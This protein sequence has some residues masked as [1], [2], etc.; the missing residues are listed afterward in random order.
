MYAK[1]RKND[2]V[3]LCRQ[4]GL[5][6]GKSTKDQ[7]IAQLEEK[8]RLDDPIPV[9]GGSRPADAAWAP[10]PDLAGRGQTA[11][12]DIPRP[13]L[14]LPR[15][16]VGESPANTEG[17]LTPAASRGS[18]RR[19]SPS[20]QWR[21]LDWEREIKLKELELRQQALK[22]ER[23][24]REKQHQ[25]EVQEKEKQR[26]HELELAR[27]RSSEAPAAVSEG[28]PKTTGKFDRNFL[29]RRKEGE[30]IDSFL[31]AFENAC[32]LHKVDPADKIQ[33]LTPLLDPAGLDVYGRMKETETGDYELFKKALL[34]E[35]G[36]TPEMYRQ[37]FRDQRKTPE[38]TYLQLANR[39][40]GYARKWTAG[41]QT[42]EGL[43]ELFVLEQLYEQC[44]SDL[45]LWLMDKNPG[46]PQH[47][48]RLAD[49]F[50]NSRSRGGRKEYQRSR[51]TLRQQESHHGTS[52]RGNRENP[53]PRGTSDIR[54]N[55]PARGDQRDMSC[56]H[57]GQRG[58]LRS[59]CPKIRDRLSRPNPHR[60]NWVGTQ[61]DEGPTAQKRGAGS[62]STAPEGGG[63][64]T[65]SSVG[66]DAPDSGFSVYRVGAGLSLRRECLVPLEI[67]GRRVTGY[68][69]TGA[70][71]TLARP[72]VV[73]PDRV[74]P[75]T[76]LTLTGVGGTPFKVPV[77][78]V[79]LKWGAKEGPKDIGVH[80]HLPTEVLMWGDLEDWPNE[81]RDTL[82]VPCTWRRTLPQWGGSTPG[83]GAER[84]RPQTRTARGNR[85]PFLPQR[86]SSRPS[87]REIPPCGSSGT[88][89]TA[90]RYRPCGEVAKRGSCGRRGSCTGNGLPPVR[91]RRGGS[92]GSWWSPR[93]IAASYCT[94]PMT[95]L[96]QGTRESGQAEAATEL[97]LAWGLY[98][99]PS[100]LPVL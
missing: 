39:I 44:P 43:L 36:L 15:G 6:V 58:H 72:K 8:D 48:G 92:G 55:R 59:Q 89:P 69:D 91:W 34:C 57:C 33:F 7:L 85:L 96:S 88:W 32:R 87:Y 97:L 5:R 94:W 79:H 23:E 19:S 64:Q 95:S 41:A 78:R 46:S 27:L 18:S 61:P 45:K 38:V 22:E 53:L 21:R 13:L 28:G 71:V 3:E 82:R 74:V 4:R 50:V 66:L 17:T 11:A 31:A 10:G 54:T 63:P 30:D 9:P 12:E 35:L 42:M 16:E 84:L 40:H 47:A 26:Q 65:S 56:Y 86:L 73:A 60:V 49:E 24:E 93:S 29:A 20:Q 25:H 67:D 62:L 1:R 2:L 77:A 81:S 76:Y 75:N 51:P 80:Q 100:V 14:P 83:P 68:W 98:N 52:Q 70:E 99:S 37:R 90:G